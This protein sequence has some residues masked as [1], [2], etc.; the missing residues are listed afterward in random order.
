MKNS[1][2]IIGLILMLSITFSANVKGENVDQELILN[3]NFEALNPEGPNADSP[4][5]WQGP[6][7]TNTYFAGLGTRHLTVRALNTEA[8]QVVEGLIPGATYRL[9]GLLRNDRNEEA[10]DLGIRDHGGDEVFVTHTTNAIGSYS[11]EFTLG[12]EATSATVFVRNSAGPNWTYAGQISMIL[13]N[14]NSNNDDG[15]S[16]L[17]AN[18]GFENGLTG[19][20]GPETSLRTNNYF[21]AEGDFHLTVRNSGSEA[22]QIVN[23]L[24]S[25]KTYV[26]TGY[27]RN[28]PT[29][30][31][32]EEVRLG[33]R[34]YGDV[35]L[36]ESVVGISADWSFF[37]I[38]FTMGQDNTSAEI[39]V[40]NVRGSNWAYADGL[41]LNLKDGGVST[42]IDLIPPVSGVV[43]SYVSGGSLF[44]QNASG[45]RLAVFNLSGV[46]KGEFLIQEENQM[47]NISS[48]PSGVYIARVIVNGMVH[49]TKIVK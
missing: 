31:V 48:L 5:H 23:G 3:G 40:R 25:G 4:M 10:V 13:I 11:F 17:I 29:G 12:A 1:N 24:V 30:D 49:S 39:F 33:V 38:E 46:N 28:N 6:A 7:R 36:F 34:N 32:E 8:F 27:I 22:V 2:Y 26:L 14:D 37:T 9:S 15:E 42:S 18:G 44:V 20:T 21:A 43:I 16:T 35:E 47:I 41:E 45:A 19:W